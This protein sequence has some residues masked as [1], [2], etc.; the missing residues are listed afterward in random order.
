MATGIDLGFVALELSQLTTVSDRVRR[1]ASRFARPAIWGTLARVGSDERLRVRRTSRRPHHD[2]RGKHVGC[3]DP[4]PHLRPDAG[5]RGTVDELPCTGI[6]RTCLIGRQKS[7][8]RVSFAGRSFF[9]ERDAQQSCWKAQSLAGDGHHGVN[10]QPSHANSVK[11]GREPKLTEYH[12]RR[13]SAVRLAKSSRDRQELCWG[14]LCV[15]AI[16]RFQE[17]G[18]PTSGG[19]APLRFQHHISFEIKWLFFYLL[20]YP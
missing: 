7:G 2:G 10:C 4:G 5:R 19:H 12:R 3:R 16:T 13:P 6:A 14:W 9:A 18:N 11:F 15:A 17:P 1:E 20:Q 8:F